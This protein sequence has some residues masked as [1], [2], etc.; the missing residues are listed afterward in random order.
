MN[1]KGNSEFAMLNRHIENMIENT[2]KLIVEVDEIVNVVNLSAEDVEGVSGQ[3]EQSSNGI[4][5]ALEEIDIGV[6]Q[7][8]NDAQDCL[9]Q[10]DNLSQTIEDVTDKIDNTSATSETTKEIVL[11]SISTMEVLS[12]QTK[13]TI[14]VTSKVKSDV[15]VLEISSSEIKKFVSIIADIAEQTNLLSLN[16]SIEAARAGEAGRGFSVVAEEIRKLADGSRQAAEEINKVVEIIEKQTHETVGTAAKAEK[17]VEE[18]A[19][20][21]NATKE[22]FQKIYQ[23]TEEVISCVDD[24]KEKVKGMDKERAG[25][26]EAISRDRKSVV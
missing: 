4:L 3:L 2:R 5:E 14:E 17:I 18:Q 24:V 16:A 19:E 8:A 10:M 26:L 15:K 20:T 22:A 25:T 11:K 12:N 1:T 9:L 13:D 21:V 7:Q 23:A 6:S